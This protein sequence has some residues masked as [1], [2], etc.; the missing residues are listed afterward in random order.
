[1]LNVFITFDTGIPD[2]TAM[3]NA[4][5]LDANL[6]AFIYGK[7][8]EGD[9]GLSHIIDILN[10]WGIKATFFVETLCI[11]ST[12]TGKIRNFVDQ[13]R[14]QGHDVQLLCNPEW[15]DYD[16][17]PVAGSVAK[18]YLHQFAGNEQT[19]I[20]KLSMTN[21]AECGV[22]S[23]TA[24]RSGNYCSNTDTLSALAVNGI[25]FDSSYTPCYQD[26][27]CKFDGNVLLTQPRKIGSV[28]EFPV[29]FF[30]DFSG[31]AQHAQISA[32]SF[33]ELKEAM[34]N[35]WQDGWYSFVIASN[36]YELAT[37]DRETGRCTGVNSVNSRRFARLCKFLS[38][39]GDKFRVTV[40]SEINPDE[41]PVDLV[42]KPCKVSI[43]GTIVRYFEQFML[44][45][46]R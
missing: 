17:T 36:S 12:G 8:P 6:D 1:M 40:F 34:L 10:I 33:A 28:L 2:T 37:M 43:L 35:A 22:T 4:E 45:I 29:S 19:L 9:Y 41:V 21:L 23:V 30:T 13:I 15:L 44:K 3:E 26:Q 7:S 14:L 39:N 46:A 25:A 20:V 11:D 5:R 42:K 16:L 38:E 18:P 24:F 27:A 32:C 31:G